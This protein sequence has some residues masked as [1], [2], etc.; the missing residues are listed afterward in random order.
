MSNLTIQ[1]V[2]DILNNTAINMF[3]SAV[4]IDFR[5]DEASEQIHISLSGE[6]AKKHPYLKNRILNL[7]MSMKYWIVSTVKES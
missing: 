3:S 1:E 5:I 2:E 7:E 4:I 6:L